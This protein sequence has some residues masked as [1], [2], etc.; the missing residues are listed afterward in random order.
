MIHDDW[1][2]G[3]KLRSIR[4]VTW[5]LDPELGLKRTSMPTIETVTAFPIKDGTL[6]IMTSSLR[7]RVESLD[8]LEEYEHLPQYQQG[9]QEDCPPLA[10]LEPG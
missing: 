9:V 5:S 10:D 8:W 4:L 6:Q 7:S 1:I 2:D 3:A